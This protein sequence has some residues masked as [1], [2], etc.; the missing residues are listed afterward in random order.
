M[1]QMRFV[2]CF[3]LVAIVAVSAITVKP[4]KEQQQSLLDVDDLGHGHENV[5]DRLA[6]AYG[7]RGGYGRGGGYRRGGHYG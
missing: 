5:G 3:L 4:F 1:L 7:R 6:R 2:L